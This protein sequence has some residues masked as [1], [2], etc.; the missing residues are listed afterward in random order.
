MSEVWQPPQ[1]VI[2]RA[3]VTRLIRQ[4]GVPN[5]D[6]LYQL[7]T[8]NPDEYWQEV[9]RFLGIKWRCPPKAYVDLSEGLPFPKWF[10]G[11]KLNWV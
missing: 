8:E 1:E 2:E 11:G 10:P 7:S 6:A 4:M 5:Y 3:Q 9:N